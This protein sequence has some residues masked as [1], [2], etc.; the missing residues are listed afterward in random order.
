MVVHGV[1]ED[2][3]A[4]HSS[5]LFPRVHVRHHHSVRTGFVFGDVR[6]SLDS[7]LKRETFEAQREANKANKEVAGNLSGMDR[8]H[9]SAMSLEKD[10]ESSWNSKMLKLKNSC[11]DLRTAIEAATENNE[12]CHHAQ[13]GEVGMPELFRR[14]NKNPEK[15]KAYGDVVACV[16]P[17]GVKK[18]VD[19]PELTPCKC[20]SGNM[21]AGCLDAKDDS[22][23]KLLCTWIQ[24]E[25]LPRKKFRK[26]FEPGG[27]C[28]LKTDENPINEQL[29]H[30]GALGEPPPKEA[31]MPF[32]W[33]ILAPLIIED[34]TLRRSKKDGGFPRAAFL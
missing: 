21:G 28:N 6:E 14:L 13:I 31:V 10:R 29:E 25:W 23:H 26:F 1:F 17:D 12:L 34:S 32:P 27:L 9:Q 30:K 18:G 3:L 15:A 5:V 20:E 2:T 33:V 11:E 19:H 8:D 4:V 7:Q 16:P 24:H 22:E